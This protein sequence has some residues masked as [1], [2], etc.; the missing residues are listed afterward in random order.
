MWVDARG[1]APSLSSAIEAFWSAAQFFSTLISFCSNG[2]AGECQLHI[3][4]DNTPGKRKREFFENF[5][6]WKRGLPIPSR[7]INPK[8][9][10]RIIDALSTH[11]DSDRI[12]RAIVQ[13]ELT[14]KNWF[15]GGE[16]LAT[17]HLYMGMEA[18]VR[19]ALLKELEKANLQEPGKLAESWKIPLK[20]LDST[21][22]KKSFSK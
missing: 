9:V 14:L 6:T 10:V 17:S 22:K 5:Q 19:V 7:K 15:K 3:A 12:R 13:Y 20:D 21:I 8:V 16:I 18:L 1:P 4:F 2:Y 11:K